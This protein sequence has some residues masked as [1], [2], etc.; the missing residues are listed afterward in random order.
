[1]RQ[2]S[3]LDAQ[4]LALE[5]GRTHGH[6]SVLATYDPVTADGRRVDA[7][8][9]RELVEQRLPL[10]PPLRWRL[11][12]V[13]FGLD[14]P[15]WVDHSSFD[16]DYHIREL[17]LP[18]P[19]D[20]RQLAEQ[21]AR[22]I[23]RPLDRSRPLWELY[24]IH[25]LADG[26]VALLTKLH[27]AAVDGVSGAEV[28]GT[29][30]D[31]TP[32]GRPASALVPVRDEAFPSEWEMLALG[33]TGMWRQ[34]V[35]ALR[36]GPRTLPHLDDVPTLRALPGV[37]AIASASRRVKRALPVNRDGGVLEGQDLVAPRTRFQGPIS[38]HRSVAFGSLPLSDVKTV[39]DR[40]GCTV[41][42]VVVTVCAAALRSWLAEQGELPDQ[43]LAAFIPISVRTP[44]QRGTYGNRV[45]VMLAELPTDEP[46]PAARLHRVATAMNAAKARHKA[47]P[48]SLLTDANHF[49]P[50]ALFARAAGV[51]ARLAAV[52]AINSAVNVAISNVPGP[53]ETLYCGGAAQRSQ[54]PISGV[55]H[56]VGLNITVFSYR[57]QLGFGIVA[58]RTQLDDAWPL[59]DAARKALDELAQLPGPDISVNSA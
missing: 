47:M 40:F 9:I 58:D 35:R 32:D 8:L 45:S 34:P 21:V 15:Y 52:P 57:D 25:R 31:P 59:L 48:A 55:L 56:G 1:M 43:P 11:A 54:F 7:T 18:D 12:S 29:L 44:E 16:L 17:A 28:M 3:N 4:F 50:P 41:N 26:S 42:D 10:L 13:P 22:I 49:I 2:L 33:V 5:D 23:A 37:K 36:A 27:H 46:D 20:D 6:V 30:L 51:T 39:K 24:V 14:H 38:A 19:G 53:P